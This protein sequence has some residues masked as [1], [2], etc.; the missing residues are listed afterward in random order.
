V[1]NVCMTIIVF[2]KTLA[3]GPTTKKSYVGSQS[4]IHPKFTGCPQARATY[5]THGPCWA[6]RSNSSTFK[7]RRLLAPC[8]SENT[9]ALV[10]DHQCGSVVLKPRN[11]K[12]AP[13]GE[14]VRSKH[15]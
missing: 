13:T 7:M 1:A 9:W 14:T 6:V 11:R 8:A 2:S 3:L 4:T 10:D 12:F 5:R 15:G